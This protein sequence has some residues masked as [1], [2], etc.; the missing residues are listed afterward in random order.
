ML[1]MLLLFL[2]LAGKAG[3]QSTSWITIDQAWRLAEKNYPLTARRRL[4]ERTREFTVAN[5]AK[6]WLPQFS[7][8]G[9]ATVQSDVTSFPAKLPIAGFSLPQYSKDQYR[10]YAEVDQVLYDGGMIRQQRLNA[11]VGEEIDQKGLEVDLY[12][13]RDRVDQLYFGALLLEQEVRQNSLLQADILNG[14]DQAQAF[15]DNGTAAPSALDELNAQLLGAD[16]QRIQQEASWDA[17]LKMLSLLINLPVDRKTILCTP[18]GIVPTDRIVRPELEWYELQK[19]SF[20]L[21]DAIANASLRPRLSLFLQGGYGRPALNMLS[22]DFEWYYLGGIRLSWSLSGLYTRKNERRLSE[23]GRRN[24]E[25]A[26]VTFL[27]NT[28]LSLQ[29]DTVQ[30]R[31]CSQLLQS[32]ARI[33]VLRTSV[34]HAAYAQFAEGVIS[35]H[36]YLVQVDAEDQARELYVLHQIQSWQAL[37]GYQYHSGNQR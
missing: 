33:I 3:A 36:D 5:A 4:L 19:R 8:N 6:A 14:I 18:P 15:V 30:I 26:E 37:Y 9:Q 1:K 11:V 24:L 12:A 20:D 17:Y 29:Q 28:R 31:A 32:D 16:Q 13:L 25:V 35:A 7:L 34:K 22:N 2:M 10:A 21:Q 27:L 23:L